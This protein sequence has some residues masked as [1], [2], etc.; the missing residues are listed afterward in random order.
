M[1]MGRNERTVGIIT[2]ND[3]VSKDT[4][5]KQWTDS[6]RMYYACLTNTL[7]KPAPKI[8]LPAFMPWHRCKD[9]KI[10]VPLYLSYFICSC[11]LIILFSQMLLKKE[12]EACMYKHSKF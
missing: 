4:F 11:L 6:I 1:G 3:G 10:V 8:T 5:H 9:H 2:S 12:L 7:L